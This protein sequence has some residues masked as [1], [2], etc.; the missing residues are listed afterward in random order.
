MSILWRTESG[1][2]IIKLTDYHCKLLLDEEVFILLNKYYLYEDRKLYE[3]NLHKDNS[4]DYGSKIEVD[5]GEI[6]EMVNS[7]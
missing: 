3:V 6:I 1:E 4:V 2:L 5:I 7:L